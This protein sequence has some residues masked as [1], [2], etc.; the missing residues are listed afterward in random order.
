MDRDI[1][2]VLVRAAAAGVRR[3]PRPRRRFEFSDRLIVLMWLWAVFHE[4]P[5]C[6]ACRR[7][8]YSSL[9]RP[10]RLPSVS[11]FCKRLSTRRFLRLRVLLHR[12]LVS[13]G[14]ND[15]LCY[16]DGKALVVHDHSTDS[17]ALAGPAGHRIRRGYKL[18][19]RATSSGFVPE[20]RVLPMNAGEPSTAR[21]LLRRLACASLVLAD[22][23]YDSYRLYDAVDARAAGCSPACEGRSRRRRCSAGCRRCGGE[24]YKSGGI[25]VDSA[26]R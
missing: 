3:L 26:K 22:A 15:L 4:R 13:A 9:L 25:T 21:R 16:L 8:S 24:P 20:Y 7:E 19:A 17:Q 1:W 6:W 11:Q 5:L 12:A 18:H 10:R 2:V 23:N 14:R